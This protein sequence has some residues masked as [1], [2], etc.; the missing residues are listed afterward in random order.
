MLS[1][2]KINNKEIILNIIIFLILISGFIICYFNMSK[3][4]MIGSI[5][6][7]W[8]LPYAL[9]SII[10][11]L[12]ILILNYISKNGKKFLVIITLIFQILNYAF[13]NITFIPFLFFNLLSNIKILAYLIIMIYEI[14]NIYTIIL[15]MKLVKKGDKN[16]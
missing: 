12:I 1:I 13:T 15:I 7:S 14:L 2:F 11:Q 5:G 6:I 3:L 9:I 16:E 4:E 8:I 10:I